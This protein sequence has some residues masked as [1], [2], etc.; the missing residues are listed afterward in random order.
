MSSPSVLVK[1]G[2]AYVDSETEEEIREDRGTVTVAGH[3]E[4]RT[5]T[6]RWRRIST[7][8]AA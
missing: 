8:C 4:P 7:C 6:A 3:G 1:K 2:K 5:A